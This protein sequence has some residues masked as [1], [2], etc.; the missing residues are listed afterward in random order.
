M[1]GKK[2]MDADTDNEMMGFVARIYFL[3]KIR[4]IEN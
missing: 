1:G 4:E 3:H 2:G